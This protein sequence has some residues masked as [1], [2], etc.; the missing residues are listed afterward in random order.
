M[1]PGRIRAFAMCELRT[2]LARACVARLSASRVHLSQQQLYPVQSPGRVFFRGRLVRKKIG[3]H[4]QR[5]LSA[6]LKK[7][8]LGA[9]RATF[10]ITI[11]YSLLT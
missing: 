5:A 4:G 7:K 2:G 6:R 11:I 9:P 1:D 3:A 10:V 8:L